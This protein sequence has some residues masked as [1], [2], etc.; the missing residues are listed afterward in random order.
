MAMERLGRV[1]AIGQGAYWGATGLWP[2]VDLRSFEAVTG[3]KTEGWLVKTVGG[4][5]AAVGASLFV[6]GVR[7]RVTPEIAL[8]GASSAAALGGAAGWYAWRGRIRNIY[9]A[10]A[11]VEALLVGA[12]VL[13]AGR[14]RR[15]ATRERVGVRSGI[16]RQGAGSP[17]AEPNFST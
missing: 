9:L 7:R 1:L 15:A 16:T 4:L 14:R 3:P 8:L 17:G 10:D 5:V 6:A 11:A 2:I 13:A 12:W